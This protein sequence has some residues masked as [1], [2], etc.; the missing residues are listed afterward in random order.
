MHD[1]GFYQYQEVEN[2]MTSKDADEEGK[3]S[4][5]RHS[6]LFTAKKK[7]HAYLRPIF[8]TRQ[9][10]LLYDSSLKLSA[11]LFECSE[12]KLKSPE[13]MGLVGNHLT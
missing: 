9:D 1:Y 8:D 3:T 11:A 5:L 13:V 12:M 4:E 10:W 2:Y 6:D 7:Q